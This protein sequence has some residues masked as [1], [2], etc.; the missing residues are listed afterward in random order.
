MNSGDL[1]RLIASAMAAACA[2]T[3][4]ACAGNAPGSSQ[5]APT[6]ASSQQSR[7]AG[8]YLVTVT[9]PAGVKAI[10]DLYGRFG[11]KG[12]KEL[13]P[14]VF[15]VTLADDPGPATMEALRKGSA[16]IKA[17][18]PNSVYRTQSGG[19]AR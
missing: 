9:G 2:A 17:V 12:I 16:Q 19:G 1:R 7:V 8:E 14:H 3:G 15:L 11:I 6:G 10:A 18:E 13:A 5:A 4:Y